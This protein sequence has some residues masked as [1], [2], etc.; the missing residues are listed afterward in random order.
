[1]QG[2]TE[3]VGCMKR[4]RSIITVAFCESVMG[5]SLASRRS[6]GDDF[7]CEAYIKSSNLDHFRLMSWR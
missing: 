3:R 6:K 5:D 2:H 4:G 7:L 1:V